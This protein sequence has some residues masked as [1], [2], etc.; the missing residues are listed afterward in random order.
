MAKILLIIKNM[1][2]TESNMDT[3]M[4][5]RGKELSNKEKKDKKEYFL[6]ELAEKK[7]GLDQLLLVRYE[8][9]DGSTTSSAKMEED[10]DGFDID[11]L[12]KTSLRVMNMNFQ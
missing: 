10:D 1:S 2:F 12:A 7:K 3:M 4:D 6:K 9:G 8:E 5:S 11:Q